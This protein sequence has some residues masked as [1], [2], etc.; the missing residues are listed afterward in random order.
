MAK[1]YNDAEKKAKSIFC[2]GAY[3]LYKTVKYKVLESAKPISRGNGGETK[4]DLFILAIDEYDNEREFKLSIKLNNAAHAVNKM[5]FSTFN[6]I[7][8]N[9]QSIKNKLMQDLQKSLPKENLIFFEKF[10][11]PKE[12]KN[13]KKG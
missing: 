9:S 8:K 6:S 7:F 1:I 5:K 3:F 13:Y 10:E 12:S 4:T 11:D 2:T